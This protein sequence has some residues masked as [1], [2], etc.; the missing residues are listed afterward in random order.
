MPHLVFSPMPRSGNYWQL[1]DSQSVSFKVVEDNSKYQKV[2]SHE[3]KYMGE[4]SALTGKAVRQTHSMVL[5][6]LEQKTIGMIMMTQERVET[7]EMV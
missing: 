2:H 3:M 1:K 7:V 4:M 5:T 6:N